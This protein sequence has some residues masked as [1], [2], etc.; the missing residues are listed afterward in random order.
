MIV[1]TPAECHSGCTDADCPY[2]HS[3]TWQYRLTDGTLSEGYDSLE[4]AVAAA[5]SYVGVET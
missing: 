2:T 3:D 1:H 5:S 4:E